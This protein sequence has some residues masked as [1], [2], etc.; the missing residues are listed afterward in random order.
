MK[1]LIDEICK[2]KSYHALRNILNDVELVDLQC[3]DILKMLAQEKAVVIYPTGT[4]KTLLAASVM[5][6]LLREKPDSLFLMFVKKDQIVQTPAKLKA[7]A[8]LSCIVTTADSRELARSV[9]PKNLEA[10][11]VIMLTHDCLHNS[12]VLDAIYEIRDKITGVIIDEAHEY[13]NFNN[14]SS[15]NVLK[16][17][18]KRFKYV[19]S[20]TATPIVTDIMQLARIANLTDSVRYPDAK[21]L[22]RDLENGSFRIYYDEGFFI[23][24]NDDELGR[25]GKPK[26]FIVSV[27]PTE[28]QKK[29]NVGGVE[30]FQ[31]CKGDG[32]VRQVLA[33]EKLIKENCQTNQ[34]GLV[35]ISQGTVLKWVCDNLDDT[36]IRYTCINGNTPISARSTI[37]Q[38]FA[39]GEYDVILTSITTAVDLDCDYVVFYE[40]TALVDQMIG[41]ARRGLK[42]KE[43]NVYFIITKDTNE[44]DYFINN[45]AARCA[46]V[47][48]ILGKG[49]SAVE[50]VAEHL[51]Y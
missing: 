18:V 29:A 42:P 34:R 10:Y 43:L 40:F 39:N 16:S 32:A 5:K 50:D 3:I 8:G 22:Y 31:I 26:G 1:M 24:R 11:N 49:N 33:L 20:L 30:L 37:E 44:E 19:W 7:F 4:G 27:E 38:Q 35:Y 23:N 6:L 48:D 13:N 51:G 9:L 45:I 14:A 36:D 21:K 25:V 17:M 28:Y 41:R 46:I 12:A 2:R 15:A 47:R